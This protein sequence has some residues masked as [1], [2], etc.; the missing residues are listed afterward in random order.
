[1]YICICICKYMYMYI[2]IYIYIHIHTYIICRIIQRVPERGPLRSL[3][4]FAR[5]PRPRPAPRW[6]PSGKGNF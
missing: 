1:M 5:P 4:N 6:A 3:V 2:H